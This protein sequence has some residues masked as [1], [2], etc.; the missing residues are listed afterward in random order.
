MIFDWRIFDHL[1][2]DFV[3]RLCYIIQF[4]LK[5]SEQTNFI[6]FVDQHIPFPIKM[7]RE[8]KGD[9]YYAISSQNNDLR[10]RSPSFHRDSLVRKG[11]LEN[12]SSSGI[13]EH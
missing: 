4:L 9:L 12:F 6:E 2:F 11:D 3:A 10:M 8:N 1:N 7:P 5:I 13:I